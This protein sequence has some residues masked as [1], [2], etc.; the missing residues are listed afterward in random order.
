MHCIVIVACIFP[1]HKAASFDKN[2][3]VFH[4]VKLSE[5]AKRGLPPARWSFGITVLLE[6]IMGNTYVNKLQAICLFKAD[7]NWLN[8][9]IFA[10]IKVQRADEHTAIPEEIF[11]RK[12]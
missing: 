11:S 7:F 10:K 3:S 8:K 6:N 12:S 5:Y 4:T 1:H 9:L 2:L